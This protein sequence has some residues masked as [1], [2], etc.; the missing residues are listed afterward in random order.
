MEQTTE[1][2]GPLNELESPLNY[3]FVVGEQRSIPLDKFSA[4]DEGIK[5]LSLLNVEEDT[6]GILQESNI[7]F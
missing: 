1:L 2:Y 5:L 6:D 4:S 7:N 3:N